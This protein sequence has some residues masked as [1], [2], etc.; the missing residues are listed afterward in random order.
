MRD[1]IR[2]AEGTAQPHDAFWRLV[3]AAESESGDPEIEFYGRISE[4][5]WFDDDITPRKFKNDLYRVGKNGPVRLRINSGGGDVIA[6]S[7]IRSII[8]SYPGHV[9]VQIDGLA[10]SAA[11]AIAM[12]G[13]E[14]NIMDTAYMMIHEAAFIV[15]LARLDVTTLEQLTAELKTTNDGIRDVYA[16][17]TGISPKEIARMMAAETWMTAKEA[18]E[19]GFAD[20]V[21]NGSKAA[22]N[23]A[24]VNSLNDFKNVPPGLLAS[25]QAS[26][27]EEQ[28]PD[29]EKEP[30]VPTEPGDATAPEDAPEGTQE[31]QADE[32]PVETETPAETDAPEGAPQDRAELAK[33]RARL[34][35]LTS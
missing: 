22:S 25:L 1:P 8:S 29:G 35:K 16:E 18:V 10:A 11:V 33:R 23:K 4:H 3:D 28:V 13:D 15:M 12:G 24:L 30:E 34:E 26:A 27:E 5:S 17:H 2:I 9:T 6:A 20:A 14:I 31:S 21:I 19:M 7:V 32:H